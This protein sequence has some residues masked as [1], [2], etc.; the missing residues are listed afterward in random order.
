MP[1]LA[2]LLLSFPLS[3]S[4]DLTHYIDIY[5]TPHSVVYTNTTWIP[6]RCMISSKVDDALPF[7]TLAEKRNVTIRGMQSFTWLRNPDTQIIYC[8][9]LI[10]EHDNA[11]DT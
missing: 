8:E 7:G 9:R 2:L 11:A 1:L 6:L 3:A 5:K 10:E 4:E